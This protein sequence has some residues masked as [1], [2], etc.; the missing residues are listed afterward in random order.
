[1]T[2]EDAVRRAVGNNPEL[3]IVRLDTEVEAA[4]VGES[5]GAFVPV[6]STEL[7]RSSISSP[8]A[9]LLSGD[10]GTDLDDWFSSTGVRQRGPW[11]FRSL[12]VSWGGVPANTPK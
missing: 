7:G 9:N 11:G 3:A 1:L 5:R 12:S 4:R 10:R 2:L 8:P 6:F